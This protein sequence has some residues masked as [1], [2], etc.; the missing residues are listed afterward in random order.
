MG[1]GLMHDERM[2]GSLRIQVGERGR[3][4]NEIF[5]DILIWQVPL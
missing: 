1:M 2:R 4:W 3:A 5:A